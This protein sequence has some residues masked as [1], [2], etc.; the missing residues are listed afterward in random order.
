MVQKLQQYGERKDNKIKISKL[1][2]IRK[3]LHVHSNHFEGELIREGVIQNW[4]RIETSIHLLYITYSPDTSLRWTLA[5][6][7]G[8]IFK[9]LNV[10]SM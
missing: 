1:Q 9:E 8:V 7:Q 6:L 3:V 5:G 10:V 2:I 4:S